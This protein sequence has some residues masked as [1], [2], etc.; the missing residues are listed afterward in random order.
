[1]TGNVWEWNWDGYAAYPTGP[2]TDPT[3]DDQ[4]TARILRGGSWRNATRGTRVS[5]RAADS[6]MR[7]TNDLGFRLAR[8]QP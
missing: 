8:T 3:G 4:G 2:V 7:K 6:P 1:M 5:R